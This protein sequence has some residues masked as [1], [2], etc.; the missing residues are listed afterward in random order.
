[1]TRAAGGDDGGPP[2]GGGGFAWEMS[3]GDGDPAAV[4][5][6][7]RRLEP[8]PFGPF[9]IL[10]LIGSGGMGAVYRALDPAAG[11]EV[12]IK[13]LSG[14]LEGAQRERFTRE[15]EVTARLEHPGIVRVHSAGEVDGLPF[16]A[17][18]LIAGGQGFA[19][20]AAPL[21][22]RA[23]VALL[24]DVARAVGH[25]HAHGVVHRD[26]KPD[27]V[28]IDVTGRPRVADFGLASGRGLDRLT[29]TGAMVG[30]PSH[31]APEQFTAARERVG[32]PTDVWALGVMLYELLVDAPPFQG[33]SL[34]EL[35]AQVAQGAFARPREVDSSVPLALDAICCQALRVDPGERYPTAGALA[36]DLDAVLEGRAPSGASTAS[37][38][39]LTTTLG[40][41]GPGG[42]RAAG[43]AAVGAALLVAAALGAWSAGGEDPRAAAVRDR[44]TRVQTPAGWR[45]LAEALAAAGPL[46]PSLAAAAHR[47]L[48]ELDAVAPGDRLPHAQAWTRLAQGAEEVAAAARL[49]ELLLELG[50][51]AEAVAPLRRAAAAGEAEE[52]LV[53]ALLAA[54]RGAEAVGPAA[55]LTGPAGQAL[56]ART[57]LEAGDLPRAEAR[58]AALPGEEERVAG[59]ADVTAARGGDPT[60]E[61]EAA[62]ARGLDGAARRALVRHLLA[63]GDRLVALRHARDA[64]ELAL[65]ED[66]AD[67][68]VEAA[69]L[70]GVDR[71]LALAAARWLLGEARREQA[72]L[73]RRAL[74]AV[75]VPP[76]A[77]DAGIR[78]ARAH[79]ALDGALSV[80]ELPPELRRVA[81]LLRARL[82]GP[83][84]PAGR[85]ALTQLLAA[86][87]KDRE[88]LGLEARRR[89]A[90]GDAAGALAALE[91]AAGAGLSPR[92]AGLI[93]GGALF[94]LGRG[95]EALAEAVRVAG[96]RNVDAEALGL[97]VRALT[98]LGRRADAQ[99][100]QARLELLGGRRRA[101]ARRRYAAFRDPQSHPRILANRRAD[102]Q[103][104]LELDP[105]FNRA[106]LELAKAETTIRQHI[107]R[108]LRDEVWYAEREPPL[109]EG[110]DL[111]ENIQDIGRF[112]LS[113]GGANGVTRALEL[114]DR[115]ED[116]LARGLIRVALVELG[117]GPGRELELAQA[118]LDTA[119][120]LR[121]GTPLALILRTF[122]HVRAGRL[123]RAEQDLAAATEEAPD[124]ATLALYRG[125]LLAAQRR[126]QLQ[127]VIA[128]LRQARQLGYPPLGIGFP[129]R[130]PELRHYLERPAGRAQLEA[131][132]AD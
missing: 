74:P 112:T 18:E 108:S 73:A 128:A 77:L 129:H 24:R 9:R 83:T 88:A 89:L 68:G 121:P 10:G 48:A 105:L 67:R 38:S 92:E 111:P 86:D 93:R 120:R 109:L 78:A 122:T 124:S 85:A 32:P 118:D 46:E 1:M 16:L 49:G 33:V 2:E 31:M 6:A 53:R 96:S 94:A 47:R 125:L 30:T 52:P 87:P 4:P 34:L 22:R 66:L 117:D 70:R 91:A 59:L 99:A 113:E 90:E 40:L 97:R 17:Y 15:G 37:S 56:H 106:A 72:L 29:A 14:R 19:A 21:D 25:A 82:A 130:Y 76:G 27:N 55:K 126:S 79:R 80:P 41:Q 98:A 28:L 132:F 102:L 8:G 107:A 65:L 104:V 44:L 58:Y 60:P 50:R 5:A 39:W 95:E 54:G 62:V 11:R 114:L 103:A 63:R 64:A 75:V 13:V 115:P 101:E 131:L 100:A 71:R 84:D 119:L 20:F 42:A 12:A 36:D 35:A 116:A 69:T 57:L 51:A 23:R 26:L 127:E 43:L 81:A 45:R 110:C 123:A 61:L 3:T 7:P